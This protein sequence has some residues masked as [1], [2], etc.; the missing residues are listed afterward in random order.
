MTK[1]A[2]S[3][4]GNLNLGAMMEGATKAAGDAAKAA[5]EGASKA[6]EGASETLEKGMGD[7]GKSLKKLFGN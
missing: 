7:A 1:G 4:V 2:G 3:A 6:V 5:G